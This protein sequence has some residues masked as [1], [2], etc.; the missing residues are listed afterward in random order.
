MKFNL[1]P[2]L[3][4]A[5]VLAL[6]A[7]AQTP[8]SPDITVS[9]QTLGLGIAHTNIFIQQGEKY[10][11]VQVDMD[12]M[13]YKTIS[14]TGPATMSLMRKVKTDKGIAYAPVGEVKFPA[15]DPNQPGEFVILFV[16][17]S[18]DK[19]STGLFRNDKISFPPDSVRVINVMRVPTGI[20]VNKTTGILQPG[21]S[22]VITMDK[23]SSRAEI[24]I[25]VAKGERWI[26]ACNNVFPL[27]NEYRRTIF[28]IDVT[29]PSPTPRKIPL[30][31]LLSMAESLVKPTPP[32][33]EVAE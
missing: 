33:P 30:I 29:S 21:E 14:Y 15:I 2:T 13:S 17:G 28:V 20:M 27:T 22:K 9:F 11:P 6:T 18:G 7:H 31:T 10:L 32:A 26:E 25:A 3:L 19:V 23:D 12:T 16:P 4:V 1:I 5:W 8:P 24:H